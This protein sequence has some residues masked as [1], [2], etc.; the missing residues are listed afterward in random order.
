MNLLVIFNDCLTDE[1]RSYMNRDKYS[2][3]DAHQ[4]KIYRCKIKDLICELSRM[5]VSVECGCILS[6]PIRTFINESYASR[7]CERH[8][9]EMH[10]QLWATERVSKI[11]HH[12]YQIRERY[13]VKFK[14]RSCG[15]DERLVP[16]K[17][18]Y[19]NLK[20]YPK[21]EMINNNMRKDFIVHKIGHRWYCCAN[22]VDLYNGILRKEDKVCEKARRKIIENNGWP[23]DEL[24]KLRDE[25]K[26]FGYTERKRYSP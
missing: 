10:Y 5:E 16:I 14:K 6:K 22:R 3:M 8:I 24:N 9:K 19:E 21:I 1:M 18:M 25:K 7:T 11:D 4:R 12:L 26:Y 15:L 13:Y 2:S 20:I 23:L 17:Y